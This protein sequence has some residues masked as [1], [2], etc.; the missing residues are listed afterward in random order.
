MET[1]PW[2]KGVFLSKLPPLPTPGK[3]ERLPFREPHQP[4]SIEY[5]LSVNGEDVLIPGMTFTGHLEL[6]EAGFALSP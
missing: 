3:L 6:A 1:L 2:D 5:S 4:I